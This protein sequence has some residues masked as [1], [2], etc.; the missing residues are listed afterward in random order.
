LVCDRLIHFELQRFFNQAS[1]DLGTLYDND[2]R[3]KARRAR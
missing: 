3:Q 2:A 1:V